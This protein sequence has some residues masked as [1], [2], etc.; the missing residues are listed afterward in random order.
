MQKAQTAGRQSETFIWAK[1]LR[2]ER[3][4]LWRISLLLVHETRTYKGV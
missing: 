1:Q 3:N 4:L 2:A